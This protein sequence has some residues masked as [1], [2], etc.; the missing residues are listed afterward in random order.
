MLQNNLASQRILAYSKYCQRLQDFNQCSSERCLKFAH[1]PSLLLIENINFSHN[2]SLNAT[3]IPVSSAHTKRPVPQMHTITLTKVTSLLLLSLF[4]TAEGPLWYPPVWPPVVQQ[5]YYWGDMLNITKCYCQGVNDDASPGHYY[6]FDYRN[7]HNEQ[8]YTLG[9][10]CDSNTTT[11]GWVQNGPKRMSFLVPECWNGHD[12]WRKEKRAEC[13]RT[14]LA[15]T[16][17]FELGNKADPHD[18]YYFNG[19]K[20]GLPNLGKLE[21]PPD[22]CAAL[23]RDKVGG[24][25]V[26]SK[27]TFLDHGFLNRL[28]GFEPQCLSRERCQPPNPS[29]YLEI[30][31]EETM[32]TSNCPGDTEKGSSKSLPSLEM[33]LITLKSSFESYTALDDMAAN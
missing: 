15:D 17:C 33:P 32:L 28:V 4:T 16:F 20:R 25:A 12:S 31:L 2:L 24:K 8:V 6:Q 7:F 9:W 10:T 5:P 21:F 13:V 11:T 30:C 18:H 29:I 14:Y 23:C 26:A 22:N 19:Q 1:V 3:A 27:C